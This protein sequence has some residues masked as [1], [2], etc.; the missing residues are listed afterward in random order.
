MMPLTGVNGET[1]MKRVE[2]DKIQ[3]TGQYL[4]PRM[5]SDQYNI[6]NDN[7]GIFLD[8]YRIALG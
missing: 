7:L 2:V 8:W 3:Y 6:C 4:P 1:L 5:L